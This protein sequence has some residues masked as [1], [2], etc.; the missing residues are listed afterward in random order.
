MRSRWLVPLLLVAA[1]GRLRASDEEQA[2][3]VVKDY[4]R[5]YNEGDAAR[6]CELTAEELWTLTSVR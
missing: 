2:G 5:A 1:G 3:Q 4:N 6:A